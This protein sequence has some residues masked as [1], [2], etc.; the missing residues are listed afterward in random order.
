MPWESE[1]A[2]AP[3]EMFP[4]SRD[5]LNLTA[6]E[7]GFSLSEYER[8]S[9]T[10]QDV[11][12]TFEHIITVWRWAWLA[13]SCRKEKG[14]GMAHESSARW[15]DWCSWRSLSN[16]DLSWNAVVCWTSG[17][18]THTHKD[19]ARCWPSEAVW[20]ELSCGGL[21]WLTRVQGKPGTRGAGYRSH[22]FMLRSV[23]VC[24]QRE[25]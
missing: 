18:K 3:K 4:S 9:H 10:V 13:F 24:V 19:G 14:V 20:T 15:V 2:Q 5:T 23:C 7:A 25:E 12:G 21:E 6:C 16:H 22:L 17:S 8:I 11:R 1:C